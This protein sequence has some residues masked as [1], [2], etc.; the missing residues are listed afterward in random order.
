MDFGSLM[1][2]AMQGPLGQATQ[3][4]GVAAQNRENRALA[5]D[6]WDRSD[7]SAREQMAFQERMSNTAHQRQ[8]A[9]LKAA[10]LNP[11][12]SA[13]G[14][15]PSP[16][17]AMASGSPATAENLMEGAAA[18]FMG[19]QQLRQQIKMN[20]KQ[21]GLMEAQTKKT[22]TEAKVIEKDIPKS[23]IINR[24]YKAFD[25]YIMAPAA[26]EFTSSPQDIRNREMRESTAIKGP[27]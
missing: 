25:K 7:A 5:S 12:L 24:L 22:N 3:A 2:A 23:D 9:D 16:S 6:S 14:G 19:M 18:N 13:N 4:I 1:S 27:R 15:A 8:V 26:K 11:I 17:G 21:I 20:D 10:G